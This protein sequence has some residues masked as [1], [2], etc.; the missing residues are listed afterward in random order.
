MLKQRLLTAAVLIPL[1]LA[2]MFMLP[3][4]WWHLLLLIPLTIAAHEWARLGSFT[5]AGE[6]AFLA[7]LLTAVAALW[8]LISQYAG[9]PL[10]AD[11]PARVCFAL[12]VAFWVVIAPCWLWLGIVV[13]N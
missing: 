2:G 11:S 12:G 8:W 4:F 7:A 10:R 1:L 5:R 6:I 3:G 9:Q 13:K